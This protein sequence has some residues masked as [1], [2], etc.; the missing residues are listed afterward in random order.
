MK[1]WVY[2]KTDKSDVD[3]IKVG[4]EVTFKVDALPKETFKGIVSQLRMNQH[5]AKRCDHH[6]ICESEIKIVPWYRL[7][8]Y[9]SS[10]RPKCLKTV[11]IGVK[12]GDSVQITE[13]LRPGDK[14]V[15]VGTYGLSDGAKIKIQKPA[16]PDF[17]EQ[18]KDDKDDK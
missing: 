11:K 3:N 2:A 15:T 13:G 17:K 1:M 14:V 4:K 12:Q 6:R 16:A 7:R 18:D 5:G 10:D 8:D 9:S